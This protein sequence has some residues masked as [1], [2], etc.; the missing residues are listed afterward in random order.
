MSK[1]DYRGLAQIK[2]KSISPPSTLSALS[3]NK[4]YWPA[5]LRTEISD[6]VTK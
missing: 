2:S 6:K 5:A 1:S 3:K 4:N